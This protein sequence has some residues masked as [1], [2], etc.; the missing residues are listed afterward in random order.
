MSMKKSSKKSNKKKSNKKKSN[1]AISKAVNSVATTVK[2]T[3][4][5]SGGTS[6]SSSVKQNVSRAV[7]TVKKTAKNTST[8]KMA[9]VNPALKNATPLKRT[10]FKTA[11]NKNTLSN[12]KKDAKAG[13]FGKAVQDN[14]NGKKTKKKKGTYYTTGNNNVA[15]LL[16]TGTAVQGTVGATKKYADVVRE[17]LDTYGSISDADKAG[18]RNRINATLK[19]QVD[20]ANRKTQKDL[21]EHK[22]KVEKLTKSENEAY[23]KAKIRGT[24]A[25]MQ[26]G[27]ARHAAHKKG[28][29]EEQFLK[30]NPDVTKKLTKQQVADYEKHPVLYGVAEGALP[31]NVDNK[32]LRKYYTDKQ[33][34]A[35]DRSKDTK[36]Y[37]AGYAAGTIG[38]FFVG[39]GGGAVESGIKTGL[40]GAMKVGAKKIVKETAEDG[41]KLGVKTA[42]KSELKSIVKKS[43]KDDVKKIVEKE[44][45]QTGK[46]ATLEKIVDNTWNSLKLTGKDKAK[47]FIA[48][49]AADAAVSTPF[50]IA[51]A[52]KQS[53][54]AK[55]ETDYK[56]AAKAFGLNTAT[57]M[58]IGGVVDGASILSKGGTYKK[59]TQIMGKRNMGQELTKEEVEWYNKTMD[60]IRSENASRRELKGASK[61]QADYEGTGVNVMKLAD[62]IAHGKN[63]LKKQVEALR[64]Q[65]RSDNEILK[66]LQKRGASPAEALEAIDDN[67]AD[68]SIKAVDSNSAK[69]YN[70]NE[71][72]VTNGNRQMG[73]KA[74]S[75]DSRGTANIRQ[76]DEGVSGRE[77]LDRTR[78]DESARTEGLGRT[79]M[80]NKSVEGVKNGKKQIR[81]DNIS[82]DIG[83]ANNIQQAEG[84]IQGRQGS[85]R[86]DRGGI[87]RPDGDAELGRMRGDFESVSLK[88]EIRNKMSASGIVDTNLKGSDYATFSKALDDGRRSNPY[89][90]Y[91]DSQSVDEL[92]SSTAKAF[93]SDDGSVGIIVKSD[94]DI[95]G[96]F[97]SGKKYKGAVTDMLITARANGG[98]KMDCYGKKLVN[99]YERVGYMPVARVPFNAE[100]VDDALLLKNKPDVYI[101]MKNADDIDTVIDK[102]TV[103]G[104]KKSTQ[105]ELDALPTFND[106]DEA[107]AYRDSL[108][109]RQEASVDASSLRPDSVTTYSIDAPPDKSNISVQYS[110]GKGNSADAFIEQAKK[111]SENAKYT[112]QFDTANEKIK[113]DNPE[114][115]KHLARAVERISPEEVPHARQTAV[116]LA[117]QVD[118]DVAEIVEPWVR[119]GLFDKKIRET[120]KAAIKRAEKEAEDGTLY[121]RF[122]DMDF[123]KSEHLFMAR[124]KVLL[125]R[126]SKAAVNDDDAAKALLEVMDKATDASSHAG[127]MLNATKLLLRTTP[128]GRLRVANKEAL[129]LQEKY[130]NRLGGK[131]I[132]LTD[133]QI[134]RI[135]KA[136]TDEEIA[137]TMEEINLELWENIPAT[138]LEKMN[139]IRHFSMLANP[140]THLRNLAGN[141][142]FKACRNIS[143]G[144]EI[145]IYKVPAVRRRIENLGGSVEMVKVSHKELKMNKKYLN[146][147]FDTNYGKANSKQR[148]I[149]TTRPDGAPIFRI[150]LLNKGS[151][152]NYDLLEKEDVV[153]TLKHEYKKNYVR[154]AKSKGV[155]LDNLQGMSKAQKRA[156]DAF[157]MKQAEI[158]TFRDNSAMANAIVRFKEKTVQSDK[159]SMKAANMV[160]ESQLPF[161]KTPVNVMR[162]SIDYSPISL[163]RAMNNLRKVSDAEALKL[164]I[165]QLSTGLTGTGVFLLGACLA[166]N[167]LITVDVG[168]VSG[169]EYYDRDMGYQ[170]YS[171]RLHFGDKEYSFTIDWLAPMQSSL[172]M[173]ANTFQMLQQDGI[174]T[175]DIFDGFTKVLDPMLDMSFMSSAKDTVEMFMETAYR[176]VARGED[177]N[178]G[179]AIMTTLFGSIPQGYMNSF[180]PQIVSQTAGLLDDKQRDTRSTREDPLGKSWE[181][182]S[183]KMVNRIPVLRQKVL[184]PKIDRFGNDV[185]TG[186]NIVL[187][188]FNAYVNPSN[189]KQIHFTKLDKEII[190]IYNHMPDGEDKNF[191]FYNFTGNPS[192]ELANGK[193]MSYEDLYKYG[194]RSRQDQTKSIKLMTESESYENMSYSMKTKEVNSAHWNAEMV[195][196]KKTYGSKYLLDKALKNE[197]SSKTDVAA[198]KLARSSGTV[199][200]DDLSE[201]MIQKE[202]L[203]ARCHETDYY[204]QA[205]AIALYGSDEIMKV[206]G[207]NSDKVAYAREYVTKYGDGAY[208]MFSDAECNV[209]S[210]LDKAGASTSTKNK[211][212][213]AADFDINEDTYMAMGIDADTANMGYGI[214]KFEYSYEALEAMK[215]NAKYGFDSDSSGTLNKD[216]IIEYIESLGLETNEEKAVL[217]AYFS[218][219]KNPYGG[220]PNYLGFNGTSSG[221]KGSKRRSGGGGRSKSGSSSSQTSKVLSWEEWVKDYLTTGDE[222]K[223]TTFKNWDSPI[224]SAYIKKIQKLIKNKPS[225]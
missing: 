52:L 95:A 214:K 201:Y 155:P 41:V 210:G 8:K 220:V 197:N 222:L 153:L 118:D 199:S 145:A 179:D 1:S 126:L 129:R 70:L 56:E 120:Q 131:A 181:S 198:I 73:Q 205:I 108:L 123:E 174:T 224:D 156:A 14:L 10:I 172:F 127:R 139:E 43:L 132:E 161:V 183:R 88:G 186:G 116:K 182:W 223:R 137:K 160:L 84:T 173:G 94:G 148:Y 23:S 6:A 62:D 54:N 31:V 225:A 71:G 79:R 82:D 68:A 101:M 203:I 25:A 187:R 194:K 59:L 39:G 167:D 12:Y 75:A 103:G 125:E 206:Y 9:A 11:A 55:G 216:E 2:N 213:S 193:R 124:A 86:A 100:Y 34:E 16:K 15:S 19:E 66:V 185:E 217:F 191:F 97:N 36:Q 218:T 91:V 149:E 162:R 109:A 105:T 180:V 83:R 80:G 121:Q 81:A 53:T 63:V 111:A 133:E 175:R 74:V 99:E 7:A 46:S 33:A 58:A 30:N 135:L 92:M 157:A 151:K 61:A 24:Y 47:S 48:S 42:T 196:D 168:K 208:K 35:I 164:G 115:R 144:I 195:A 4:A 5:S 51:D 177:P 171:L 192:Y 13:K 87:A 85:V 17:H 102:V 29:T 49:R 18:Y 21:G 69:T 178:F 142:A 130:A 77:R 106:Y 96:A 163:L 138:W 104:Y 147:V 188:V 98:T 38:S 204:T 212:I 28:M 190:D 166:A 50:N 150:K 20:E 219:A 64:T 110:R 93:L 119:D 136:E 44:I 26:G 107:L 200:D 141:A 45:K 209:I 207:V 67:V 90:G 159:L 158:A 215:M 184:N 78:V 211:A 169:D 146:E 65:G 57:D 170:D 140:K 143:D 89:G 114:P 72:G 189:V 134:H 176:D 40:K 112:E 202:K 32:K 3:A 113:Y 22:V 152:L 117:N 165:H 154:W 37:K 76:V 128:E 60:K 27:A 122:M 221:G